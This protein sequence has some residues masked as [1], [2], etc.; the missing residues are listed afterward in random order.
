MKQYLIRKE[1]SKNPKFPGYDRFVKVKA[2][3]FSAFG[4]HT[5]T[6]KVDYSIEYERNGQ[7]SKEFKETTDNWEITNNMKLHVRDEEFNAI[8]NEAYQIALAGNKL[9]QDH[10]DY[11]S[12]A[13]LMAIDQYVMA[14]AFDYV[15]DVLQEKPQ[16]MWIILEFY[17]EEQDKDSFFDF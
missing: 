3:S 11:V 4:D 17:V 13:E 2:L 1:I 6:I 8:E 10:P 16:L 12:D 5:S 15:I 7:I 9:P 14:P